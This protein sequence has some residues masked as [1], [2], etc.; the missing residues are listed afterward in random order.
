MY[1]NKVLI[2]EN[3]KENNFDNVIND[4]DLDIRNFISYENE[5]TS[6]L[7]KYFSIEDNNVIEKNFSFE[8][9]NIIEIIAAKCEI[10]KNQGIL[11]VITFNYSLGD[12]QKERLIHILK[13]KELEA[14]FIDENTTY[15]IHKNI[16]Q[17]DKIDIVGDVHGLYYE[18]VSFIKTLGYQVN[19][20]K[21]TH[22][23]NRKLL[24]LGDII[25]RGQESIK[26]LE[27]VSNA[28]KNGHFCI[29]GNHEHKI[30]QFY[31]H[32]EK[33]NYIKTSSFS[34]SETVS[35]LLKID[36]SLFEKYI[37]FIENLPTYYIF[38]D[39]AFVHANV[40]YFKPNQVINSHLMFG[41]GKFEDTDVNYQKLFDKKINKYTLIR[42]HF[43]QNSEFE[44]IFSLE[45]EQAFAG[46]L[47]ILPLDD[48]NKKRKENSQI[49]AFNKSL[50]T[51]KTNYNYNDNK[52]NLDLLKTI[53][54]LN[55]SN[56]IDLKFNTKRTYNL[57][58]YKNK[59]LSDELEG[60][61]YSFSGDILLKPNYYSEYNN[62]SLD[63]SLFIS[64]IALHNT[65]NISIDPYS[66]NLLVTN[67]NNNLVITD[68]LN[69]EDNFNIRKEKLIEICLKYN[70][71]LIT[72][73]FKNKLYLVNINYNSLSENNNLD[74]DAIFN[75]LKKINIFI[76]RRNSKFKDINDIKNEN[77][78]KNYILSNHG[79][80]YIVETLKSK[81]LKFF[82]ALKNTNNNLNLNGDDDLYNFYQYL[83]TNYI[84]VNIKINYNDIN[85]LKGIIDNYI[86]EL[87]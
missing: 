8:D 36:S 22:P 54:T 47:A 4:N 7:G 15:N 86:N 30:I 28:V 14:K 78:Y 18:L 17:S 2:F 73:N 29:C 72:Q 83:R 79:K 74:I 80:Y 57:I 33:F 31:K 52:G 63:K 37:N 24:F 68:K 48:F 46:H 34:S 44:N 84:N 3:F 25:D 69:L 58:N 43:I 32:Y 75:E 6:V 87:I 16:L 70:I 10:R 49:I 66:R 26:M 11:S 65:L 59:E 55:R 19:N 56:L 21:I 12:K 35:K 50:K 20:F 61:I 82:I 41:T 45:M 76:L 51:Y 38:K 85:E 9:Y 81:I 67:L 77:S 60:L 64:N 40:E 39:L 42:G 53:N 5:K 23:E 1:N 13:N 71:T 62:F 27:L